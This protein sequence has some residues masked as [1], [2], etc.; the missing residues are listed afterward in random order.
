MKTGR[1]MKVKREMENRKRRT[2][3]RISLLVILACYV[4]PWFSI[5]L[6]DGSG[7]SFS[8]Y[9]IMFGKGWSGVRFKGTEI[10]DALRDETIAGKIGPDGLGQMD[11][12]NLLEPS[13][14]GIAAF[15]LLLASVG[16]TFVKVRSGPI[17][18]TILVFVSLVVNFGIFAYYADEVINFAE[19]VLTDYSETIQTAYDHIAFYAPIF[20]TVI[21]YL[22]SIVAGIAASIGRSTAVADGEPGGDSPAAGKRAGKVDGEPSG[23][24]TGKSSLVSGG[25]TGRD[26]QVPG[27]REG[28]D[29]PAG[30]GQEKEIS[31]F[32]KI[33]EELRKS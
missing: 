24:R 29:R 11:S 12:A 13:F 3:L 6:P 15:V 9:N 32:A 27:K 10:R 21:A 17:L 16:L 28:R 1:T 5:D 7:L 18:A 14:L 8:G 4:F 26:G 33:K 20:I 19:T 23:K 25:Q 31:P 22:A 30:E 2:A